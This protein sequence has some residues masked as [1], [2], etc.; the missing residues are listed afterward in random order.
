MQKPLKFFLIFS[1]FCAGGCATQHTHLEETRADGYSKISDTVTR[2]FWDSTSN[3]AKLK[4]S[5]TDKTQSIGITDLEQET[6]S[7]N[8][9]HLI[10]AVVGAAI[11]AAK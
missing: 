1:L 4:T 2:T 3:L 6:S 10:E 5:H 8:T 11:K 9:T 7:T